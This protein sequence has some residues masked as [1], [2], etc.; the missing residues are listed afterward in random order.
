[1]NF[2]S[3]EKYEGHF[4]NNECNG[5]GIFYFNNGDKTEGKFTKHKA[6]GVH[7][8]NLANGLIQKITY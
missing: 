6:S 1:M 7:T 2:N 3:G 8:R 4:S 5:D